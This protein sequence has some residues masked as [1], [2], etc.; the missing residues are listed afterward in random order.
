MSIKGIIALVAKIA[1]I[2]DTEVSGCATRA[3]PKRA[4]VMNAVVLTVLLI[5]VVCMLKERKR[6]GQ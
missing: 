6:A 5:I 1:L 3:L 2:V 4:S